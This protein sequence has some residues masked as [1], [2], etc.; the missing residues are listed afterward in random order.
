MAD[1]ATLPKSL[2]DE[3]FYLWTQDQ[4]AKLRARA[5]AGD[6]AMD[7]AFLAEEVEDM[8]RS[9][10]AEC[11]S[12][13]RVIIEHLYKLAWSQNASPGR[14]WRRTIKTQRAELETVLTPS[15][16]RRAIIELEKLHLKALDLIEEDFAVEEPTSTRD[17]HLRWSLAQILGEESDPLA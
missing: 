1:S 16:R 7:W 3:D 15:L 11:L 5:A 13:I 17:P 10:F 14:A 8:G 2:Y 4:A 6:T 9:Q 12:R